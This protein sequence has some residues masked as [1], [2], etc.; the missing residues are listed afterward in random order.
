MRN[1]RNAEW[2]ESDVTTHPL[3]LEIRVDDDLRSTTQCVQGGIYVLSV[4]CLALF[5]GRGHHLI[6]RKEVGVQTKEM[7]NSALNMLELEV[8][9]YIQLLEV[10]TETQK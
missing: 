9:S 1:R 7:M 8:S 4:P 6:R 3:T 10:I 5:S 2:M